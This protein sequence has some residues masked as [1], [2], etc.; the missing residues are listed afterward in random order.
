V[1]KATLTICLYAW[2]ALIPGASGPFLAQTG[3]R[4]PPV[5][6]SARTLSLGEP[7]QTSKLERSDA[8]MRYEN[9]FFFNIHDGNRVLISD[10]EGHT[11]NEIALSPNAT[12]GEEFTLLGIDDLVI[13]PDGTIIASLTYM[14]PH[15]SRRYFRLIH[16]SAAGSQFEAIDLGPWRALRLCFADD[17]TIWTLSDK[18]EHGHSIYSADDNIL[19]NYK[20]GDG[21]RQEAVPR[22]TFPHNDTNASWTVNSALDCSGASVHSLIGGYSAGPA[23]WVSYTP[24]S[25]FTVMRVNN[26][27]DSTF[28]SS[29][30]LTGFAYLPKGRAYGFITSGTGSSY[31]RMLAEL[32]PAAKDGMTLEWREIFPDPEL[33]P[34]PQ[35]T[36]EADR[37]RVQPTKF[38]AVVTGL[39]GVDRQVDSALVYR[40]GSTDVITWSVPL[41]G[42]EATH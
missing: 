20:F 17:K 30:H 9:G 39:Y 24:G 5:S 19:R 23:Q 38:S 27:D 32:I 10:R 22:S 3:E 28:G 35:S 29:W 2:T 41:F 31:R 40:I 12:T 4:L 21:L 15:D 6:P 26:I 25:G 18:Q 33:L 11:L 37:S 36:P 13:A 14:R 7:I 42:G 34:S 8:D 1:N 16:Y